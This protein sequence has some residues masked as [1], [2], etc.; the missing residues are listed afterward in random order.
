MKANRNFSTRNVPG[1]RWWKID[2]HAHTPASDSYGRG[3]KSVPLST[4]AEVWLQKAM[5]ANLDCVIVTDHNSGDWIDIL[6]S[7]YRDLLR[8]DDKPEWFRE[9][10]I[11]PGVEVSVQEGDFRIP[12]LVVFDIASGREAIVSF[13]GRCEI[14][15]RHGDPTN[16]IVARDFSEVVN[17]I[18]KM[19]GIAIPARLDENP[20]LLEQLSRD[21]ALSKKFEG[22]LA[23]SL[24]NPRIGEKIDGSFKRIVNRSAKVMGSD[25]YKPEELGRL[26]SWV[27]MSRPTLEQLETSVRGSALCIRNQADPP[28]RE[29][30]IFLN[31]LSIT[32]MSHC[33]R[34]KDRPFELQ[35]HPHF[36]T[37]IGGRGSGKS[38]AL[39][40]VRIATRR[41][42]ELDET[43]LHSDF[44]RFIRLSR[45]RGVMLPETEIRLELVRREKQYRLSWRYDDTGALLEEWIDDDG[46]TPGWLECDPG[47]LQERFPLSIYS[48]KQINELA[49]NPRSLLDIIDRTPDVAYTEWL[50][51]W[52][53]TKSRYLQYCERLREIR[54]ELNSESELRIQLA[55]V[56]NDLKGFEEKGY[57]ES[58]PLYQARN[59]QKDRLRMPSAWDGLVGEI[60]AAEERLRMPE[61]PA[62]AFEEGDETLSE[63]RSLYDETEKKL[64]A[65]KTSLRSAVES[66]SALHGE[67][68]TGLEGTAWHKS[69]EE[70]DARY[71]A[72]LRE[73][74]DEPQALSI[75][76]YGRWIEKRSQLLNHLQRMDTLRRDALDA[77]KQ[78]RDARKTL[79]V[80]RAELREKRAGFIRR[81]IGNS[82]YVRMELAPFGDVSVLDEEYRTILG[83]T[84]GSFESSI[85]DSGKN[86]E[87]GLLAE[88]Y[89]W[90]SGK[91]E[92]G[93]KASDG[94][95]AGMEKRLCAL[96]AEV[97][98]ETL[99][100]ARKN[101]G[102]LGKRLKK[103]FE[104]QPEVADRLMCWW[105]EDLLKIKYSKDPQ[106]AKFYDL[107]KGS[108]GQKAAAVLAFLLSY[109]EEPLIIDQP[110]DD[111]D[112]TLISDLIVRQI[113]EHKD[114]RQLLIVTHNPNIVVNG[115]A[116]LVHALCYV[117][118]QVLLD[119]QGGLEEK[120]IRQSICT[121]IEGGREA[122]EKRYRKLTAK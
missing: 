40:S 64:N 99:R 45:E 29:P 72:L 58:L 24:N 112:N 69:L 31:R 17:I 56:E 122:L 81:V 6:N 113:H 70:C 43:A 23:F 91:P 51:R 35:L 19:G 73:H 5:E 26:F 2:F 105:P 41:G 62:D 92:G 106:N 46:Q 79:R 97:K 102:G 20:K 94:G 117:N 11:F 76:T 119:R 42:H 84:D 59:R 121:I 95:T 120:E 109:G 4:T 32:S 8:D 65:A 12:L 82:P 1:S 25:S 27:R 115:D 34:I 49:A 16:V 55:D 52:D 86:N 116:D 80:L 104:E 88:L 47:N 110:E 77:V 33:G 60:S 74:A 103:I 114:H 71:A 48:Q 108:A 89:N 63:V 3:D 83:L 54:L 21:S 10:T 100:H 18:R 66:L 98:H 36:N 30:D 90:E 75:S 68:Q 9:L 85:L 13:L 93:R 7:Q 61:F 37:I 87:E 111:L 44:E 96:I 39:E 67:W 53:K 107:E 14:F 101:R 118:G 78:I 50:S 22:I 38:T 57:K 28:A 15:S